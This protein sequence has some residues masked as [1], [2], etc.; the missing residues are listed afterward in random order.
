MQI[1][2]FPNMDIFL[3]KRYLTQTFENILAGFQNR[4]SGSSATILQ[5]KKSTNYTEK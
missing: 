4:M 3:P 1:S 5:K 2:A